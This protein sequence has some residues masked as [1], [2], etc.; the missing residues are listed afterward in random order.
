MS[1]GRLVTRRT[2]E[3]KVEEEL[4]PFTDLRVPWQDPAMESDQKHHNLPPPGGSVLPTF[5]EVHDSHL[6]EVC[7]KGLLVCLPSIR[8]EKVREELQSK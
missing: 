6:R 8:Q 1:V 5:N 7:Q 4:R 2:A 3:C